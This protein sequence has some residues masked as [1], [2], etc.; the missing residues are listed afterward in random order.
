[1]AGN[2]DAAKA[3]FAKVGGARTDLAKFWL[4]W[5]DNQV[6]ANTAAPAAG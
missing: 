4:I 6:A 5:V 3:A 1:M 2:W